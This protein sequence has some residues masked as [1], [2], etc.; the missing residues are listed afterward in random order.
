MVNLKIRDR[1]DAGE[2]VFGTFV[3]IA[4]P[5]VVEL[6]ALGGFDFVIVDREHGC[7]TDDQVENM[8]RAAEAAG[9][10]TIVR[11]P[12]ALEPA[13]LHA[14]DSGATGVQLPALRGA[15]QA[16]AAA[17][18]ARH[19]PDGER[20]LARANRSADYGAMPLTDYFAQSR[21][22]LVSVHVE[23]REMVDDI[24]ALCAV[25]GVDILFLGTADLSQ[26]L[27]VPGEQDH[28]SVRAAVDRV[29]AAAAAAGRHVGAVA[30]SADEA[31]ALAERG[32]TYIV[33]Q[34]DIAMLRAAMRRGADALAPLRRGLR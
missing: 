5:A 28:P 33:W 19:F 18:F 26:S 31:S 30:G 11:T 29:I 17:R 14:L 13:I 27:G 23:N 6:A 9:I 34:S 25:P 1:L 24:D 15:A 21:R 4:A 2:P 16:A 10:G 20:G 7:F 22:I 8:I 32:V 12:D 3:K